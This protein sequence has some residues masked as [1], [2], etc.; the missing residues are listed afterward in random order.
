MRVGVA[1]RS[2]A[3]LKELKEEFPGQVEY[4]TVDVTAEDAPRLT[5]TLIARL[6]GMDTYVHVAGVG[7][8]NEELDPALEMATLDVNVTGFARWPEPECGWESPPV[9]RRS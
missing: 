4:E 1:A 5:G 8:S 9:P 6:G 3:K 2:T 7:F